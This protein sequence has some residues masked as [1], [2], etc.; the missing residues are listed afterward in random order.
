MAPPATASVQPLTHG[1]KPPLRVARTHIMI[2]TSSTI[3][4]LHQ[5]PDEGS[6]RT[7]ISFISNYRSV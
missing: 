7:S 4:G 2:Y 5:H 3:A 1:C 6:A